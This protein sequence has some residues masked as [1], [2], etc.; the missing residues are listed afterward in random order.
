MSSEPSSSSL[1][2]GRRR[3]R[4]PYS[5][6]VEAHARSLGLPTTDHHHSQGE[7]IVDEQDARVQIKSDA[8]ADL[9]G[10]Q[11]PER[12]T[13][14]ATRSLYSNREYVSSEPATHQQQRAVDIVETRN[15]NNGGGASEGGA[16]ALLALRAAP[17]D[18]RECGTNSW[19]LQAFQNAA[20]QTERDRAAAEY[21]SAAIFSA[22]N[23]AR[24]TIPHDCPRGDDPR[25][26]SACALPGARS[27]ASI[28]A[29]QA[30]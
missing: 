4:G 28:Y 18:Q 6:V 26:T 20:E 19:L 25:Y 30:K 7:E 29:R 24:K 13:R 10:G 1:H 9:R 3:F 14:S 21:G 12:A 17:I 23:I 27:I 15:D 5:A 16:A 8:L 22:R 2:Q 11:F